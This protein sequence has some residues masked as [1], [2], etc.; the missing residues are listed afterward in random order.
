MKVC[1]VNCFFDAGQM[2]V[3]HPDEC[4]DCGL[5]VPEC[6]VEAIHP[7]E[8]VSD[9]ERAFIELNKFFFTGGPPAKVKE[10]LGEAGKALAAVDGPAKRRK[11]AAFLRNPA[12]FERKRTPEE[13]EKLRQTP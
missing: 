7:L 11:I 9:Q 8:D 5:C 1:P 4:I 2:L 12:Q 10:L 13:L 3:I 6:P